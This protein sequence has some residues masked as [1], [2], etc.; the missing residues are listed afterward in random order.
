M[1]PITKE[2]ILSALH[3][4]YAVKAFDSSKKV[5]D[6][7]IHTILESARLSPSSIGLEPWK[8]IVVKNL[9]LREKIKAAGYGQTKITEASHL[10]VIAHRTDAD[11]LPAE[12]NDR[13]SKA[14]GKLEEDL[15]QLKGMSEG[16]VAG[17]SEP[18]NRDGW[19]A[20][21]TYIPLGIMIETAALMGID[22]G[23]MEGFNP[24]QVD[25]ILG[26]KEKN[27]TSNS[28]LAIG[29]RGEDPYATLPKTRRSFE[30]VVEIIE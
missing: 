24:Q 28:M 12:L 13:T 16:A 18:I 6:D 26:L 17:H 20:S 4:R 27:L 9:E 23:P 5:S 19:L 10:I 1:G 25:E 2:Q 14:Q 30:E 11:A 22:T 15:A 21:Q 3:W 8:F 7:D 29:Y